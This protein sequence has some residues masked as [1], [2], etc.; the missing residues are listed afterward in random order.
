MPAIAIVG[1]SPDRKKYGNKAVRAF[2]KGGWTVYP[3]HP[4]A[5]EIEGVPA[6]PDLKSLPGPVDR[7]SMYV[8]PAVGITLIED[9]AALKPREF[10]LNPGAESVEL[11]EKARALGL[12]PVQ[13]CSIVNIGLRPDMFPDT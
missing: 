3:I 4:T 10:F 8:P 7:V 13:A 12:E 11:L 1:A 5:R 6:Y 2:L 9:I